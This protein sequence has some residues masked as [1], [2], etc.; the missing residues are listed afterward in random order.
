MKTKR[1]PLRV[2]VVALVAVAAIAAFGGLRVAVSADT[3][4]GIAALEAQG[5]AFA[6]VA[7]TA[8]PAVVNIQVKKTVKHASREMRAPFGNE[9]FLRRF[10][11][12]LPDFQQMPEQP[13]EMQGQGSGFIYSPDGYIMT[14]NHVVGDADEVMVSLADGREFEAKVVG[15]D[16]DSDVAVIKIDGD[17]L[18]FLE[19]A[20]SDAIEVGQWVVAIGSPFGFQHTVTAGIVSATGRSGLRIAEFEDFIQTDAAI[21]PG[22]SGGPLLDLYGRAIGMNT[23]IASRTGQFNGI[24]LA[25]PINM[26]KWVRDQLV[27]GGKVTRGYLGVYMQPI[28]PDLAEGFGLDKDTHGVVVE[29]AMEDSPAANAGIERGDVITKMDGRTI[30]EMGAFRNHIAMLKPGDRVSLEVMR[31]NDSKTFDIAIA[32]RDNEKLARNMPGAP[33][34]QLEELGMSVQELTPDIAGQMGFEDKQG[35]IV[36]GV[37]P[38]SPAYDAGIRPGNLIE[39]VNRQAVKTTEGFMNAVKSSPAG[40]PVLMLVNDDRQSRFVAVKTK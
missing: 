30:D 11:P 10:F 36:T 12:N 27:D 9:D 32:E 14:N 5:K 34:P 22:N 37:E 25:I 35:V 39:E 4:E 40:K 16:K 3:P 8:S 29:S 23:A 2:A 6:S 17:N 33:A 19:F 18:P 28:T 24:G 26:A 38:G 7:K 1:I 20:D 15:A 31:G 21:N 13:F